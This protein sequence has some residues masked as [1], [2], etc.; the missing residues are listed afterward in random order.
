MKRNY[1]V[2]CC[3]FIRSRIAAAQNHRSTRRSYVSLQLVT[4]RARNR[5]PT[6]FCLRWHR[7]GNAGFTAPTRLTSTTSELMLCTDCQTFTLRSIPSTELS[8]ESWRVCT[9]SKMFSTHLTNVLCAFL[10]NANLWVIDCFNT[11]FI[12]TLSTKKNTWLLS[13]ILPNANRFSQFF[14]S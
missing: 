14:H 2:C 1:F 11:D 6:N 4:S 10:L 3:S 9:T 12:C 8:V 13:V 7:R 5:V